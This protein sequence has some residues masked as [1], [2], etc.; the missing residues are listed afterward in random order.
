[1]AKKEEEK[2][3]TPIQFGKKY[4]IPRTTV[5]RWLNQKNLVLKFKMYDAEPIKIAGRQ[6]IKI[7]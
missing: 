4:K 3:L 2:V 5:W 6:F 7:K 1:M